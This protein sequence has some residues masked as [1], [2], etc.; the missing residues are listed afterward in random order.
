MIAEIAERVW[1][2]IQN[3]ADKKDPAIPT[4]AKASVAL[5]SIL[6]TIAVSVID[7]NGSAIPAISA[8][9]A[10]LFICLNET[11]GLECT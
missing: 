4:A 11:F 9:K 8:G 7:N 10:N 6:P 1:A 2:K 3:K 5:I